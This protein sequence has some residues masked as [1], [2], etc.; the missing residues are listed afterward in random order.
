MH[1]FTIEQR[2]ALQGVLRAR[3]EAPRGE[4]AAALR[5]SGTPQALGLANHLDEIDDEAVADLESSVEIAARERDV[6][7]L[8]ATEAT[9]ARL[10]TPEC[11]LCA[12]CGVEIP[13]ARLEANPAAPRCLP[14]QSRSE[15]AQGAPT[16]GRL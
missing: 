2:E 4:I 6:R 7:E 3:A 9:L 5:A 14:C 15:R 11:G 1:Y 10:H 8:R 16:P 12:D 13:Y